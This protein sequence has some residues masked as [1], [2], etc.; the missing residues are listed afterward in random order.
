V[1]C[2]IY[3]DKYNLLH[4]QPETEHFPLFRKQGLGFIV[5][6]PL[7]QG[8]LTNRYINGIPDDS[9][10][11]KP[12]GFLRKEDIKPELTEKIRQLNIFAEQRGQSLAQ[13]SLAWLLAKKDVSS[14]IVGASS[15]K[16]LQDNILCTGNIVF[17]SEELIEI[18]N[19]IG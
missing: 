8:L 12:H 11:A 4:R 3:Q 2:L 10:A 19:I 1:R 13:M 9:R 5:F 15:V 14:V 17:S 6:S 18:E 7:A 16:Q